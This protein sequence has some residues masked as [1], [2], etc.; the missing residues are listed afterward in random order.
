M[1]SPKMPVPCWMW[2][3]DARG[4]GVVTL[5]PTRRRIGM[6]P[7]FT[8]AAARRRWRGPTLGQK[9]N[10]ASLFYENILQFGYS[11][12]RCTVVTCKQ[13]SQESQG[14]KVEGGI[15]RYYLIDLGVAHGLFFGNPLQLSEHTTLQRH[16]AENPVF[17]LNQI[18]CG[19]E[20]CND[21]FV[22]HD[23]PVVVDHSLQAMCD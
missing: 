8:L 2:M 12:T 11:R 19:I 5:P 22:Q 23:Q 9:L 17:L 4:T 16:I 3:I 1:S 15:S 20:L 10:P 7:I 13:S 18:P 6:C 21:T 14:G